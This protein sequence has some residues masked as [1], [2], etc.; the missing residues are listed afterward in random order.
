MHTEMEIPSTLPVMVLQDTV[1]FPQSILPLYI[2]EGRYRQMLRDVLEGNR[3]FAVVCDGSAGS[4]DLEGEALRRVGTVGMVRASHENADG[5]SNLVLQGLCRVRFE[6]VVSEQ[7]YRQVRLAPL[8]TEAPDDVAVL[9]QLKSEVATLHAQEP[10]L[11]ND[12]PEEFLEF[13][14]T[15]DDLDVYLDLTAYSACPSPEVKQRLLETLDL[16]TRYRL[17]LAYLQRRMNRFRFHRQLQGSL[18]DEDIRLN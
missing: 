11:A 10:L 17:Y 2:F 7:P 8:R 13:L 9:R 3:L 1:F 4:G 6:G 15:I 12:V 14:Q 5:S 18:S 16:E